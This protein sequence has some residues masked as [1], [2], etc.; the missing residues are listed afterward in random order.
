MTRCLSELHESNDE[1]HKLDGNRSSS[2]CYS[3][4]CNG[5]ILEEEKGIKSSL[6]HE[7]DEE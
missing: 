1:E 7:S 6:E 2:S 5:S 4:D 3:M